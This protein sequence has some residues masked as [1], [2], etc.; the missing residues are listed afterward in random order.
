MN[1]PQS[2]QNQKPEIKKSHALPIFSQ[3]LPAAAAKAVKN[4]PLRIA[5][6]GASL[7]KEEGRLKQLAELPDSVALRT[8]ANQIKS[9]MLDHHDAYI[10]QFADNVRKNGG[11]VHFAATAEEANQHFIDIA[12]ANNCK[13]IVKSKSMATEETE[14]NLALEAAG[15]IPVETDL[16]E[17][18]VQLAHDRPSHIVM[19][20]MHL[21][22]KQVGEVFAKFFNV[23]YTDDPPTLAEIARV[24]LRDRF[25]QADMGVS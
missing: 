25:N 18:I 11:H 17:L 15:L 6:S 10:Q 8:L 13:L 19:P 22:A 5:T 23:P 12:R 7:K 4:I 24:Y 14:L 3:D 16:G 9:H 20:I 2:V 21:K 1:M